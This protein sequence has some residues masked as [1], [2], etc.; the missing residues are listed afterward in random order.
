MKPYKLSIKL[1]SHSLDND[2]HIKTAINK[3]I[4]SPSMVRVCVQR[5]KQDIM[6]PISYRLTVWY[7]LREDWTPTM[8]LA[9]RLG[10]M[11]IDI[12][13]YTNDQKNR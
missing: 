10:G 2:I 9:D 6:F 11:G 8:F 13:E 12:E 5:L 4:G 1:T 7:I 3:L